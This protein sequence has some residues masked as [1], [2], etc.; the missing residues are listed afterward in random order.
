MKLPNKAGAVDAPMTRLFAF[1][2]QWRR[3]TDQRR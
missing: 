1:D 2:C 3:A